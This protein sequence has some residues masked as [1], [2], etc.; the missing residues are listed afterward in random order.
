MLATLLHATGFHSQHFNFGHFQAS[1]YGTEGCEEL[2]LT[3]TELRTWSRLR[4]ARKGVFFRSKSS[5]AFT[6]PLRERLAF[7]R[8]FYAIAFRIPH[9]TACRGRMVA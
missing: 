6:F 5:P 1:V 4:K 3:Y 2:G 8:T 9:L 7:L